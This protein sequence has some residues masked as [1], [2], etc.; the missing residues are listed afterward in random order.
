MF[1]DLVVQ[2]LV[3]GLEFL[4]DGVQDI[5]CELAVVGTYFDDE[6]VLRRA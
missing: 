6:I 1:D 5:E 2:T 3:E 4:L